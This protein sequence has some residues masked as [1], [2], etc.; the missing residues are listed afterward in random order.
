MR[1]GVA[2]SFDCIV[3][4]SALISYNS[5]NGR[6]SWRTRRGLVVV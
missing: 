5:W 2:E 4:W 3:D 6:S 1:N